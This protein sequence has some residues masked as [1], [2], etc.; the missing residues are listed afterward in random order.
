M[1]IDSYN[2]YYYLYLVPDVELH[3]VLILSREE[4]LS[5]VIIPNRRTRIL[6]EIRT[7]FFL[8]LLL[9][10]LKSSDIQ[11]Q[12]TTMAEHLSLRD[13]T[14]DGHGE[15]EE[16]EESV[17]DLA[18]DDHDDEMSTISDEHHGSSTA[19]DSQEQEQATSST[20]IAPPHAGNNP[21]G[22][23]RGTANHASTTKA[24]KNLASTE[25]SLH[26]KGAGSKKEA[27]KKVAK[28]GK[29]ASLGSKMKLSAGEQQKGIAKRSTRSRNNV[30]QQE[31]PVINS[32][33][34][35]DQQGRFQQSVSEFAAAAAAKATRMAIAE[36]KR[37][38]ENMLKNMQQQQQQMMTQQQMTQPM[39]NNMLQPIIMQQ[40]MMTQQ[41]SAMMPQEFMMMQN[42]M[43]MPHSIVYP[44]QEGTPPPPFFCI[45]LAI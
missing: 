13:D 43:M 20:C 23:K 18:N 10:L 2:N 11:A 41:Q 17:V 29:K 12:V 14:D 45:L 25:P 28:G 9:K 36:L 34:T 8:K 19:R 5:A 24:L 4:F 21:P 27:A 33:P 35:I 1:I 31:A 7:F 32:P 30:V 15:E 42:S 44:P 6:D 37:D 40:H 39:E 38:Q 3:E 22:K 26:V 16:E